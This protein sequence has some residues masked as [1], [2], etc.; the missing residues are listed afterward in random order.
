MDAD[1]L[2]VPTKLAELKKLLLKKGKGHISTGLVQ[3]FSDDEL[4]EGYQ[5]YADWLND[6][7]RSDDPYDEIYKECVIPSPCWMLHKEDLIK[8]GAFSSDIYPED[9]DL[10]FRFFKK[11]LIPVS[12]KTVL[13]QWRDHRQR[14]SRTMEVYADQRFFD[15]KLNYFFELSYYHSRPIVLWGAGKNGKTLAKKLQALNQEFMWVCNN[16]NK[17]NQDIFGVI[18]SSYKK[19]PMIWQP[20]ILISV[21]SPD[22]KKEIQ[23]FLDL[24]GYEKNY[25]YFYF[26]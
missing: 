22:G 12:T 6:L 20:Q 14:S 23:H 4:G 21:A 16:P 18:L 24:H 3:Y 17:W 8:C 2:M 13:H 1:D 25:H 5:K 10:C 9:Y 11:D 7:A 19:L 15:L 26:V